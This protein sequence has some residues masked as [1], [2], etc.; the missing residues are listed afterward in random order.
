MLPSH[1][2]LRIT[3]FNSKH[4][5]IRFIPLDTFLKFFIVSL[6]VIFISSP[7]KNRI[8][9]EERK[10]ERKKNLSKK[11]PFSA[12]LLPKTSINNARRVSAFIFY[13]GKMESF[14]RCTHTSRET[15]SE[16][17]CPC[18]KPKHRPGTGLPYI[19]VMRSFPRALVRPYY[20]YLSFS[21][22]PLSWKIHKLFLLLLGSFFFII[23]D[24]CLSFLLPLLSI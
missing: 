1:V 21:L 11:L 6:G 10:K 16:A 18:K 15:A 9:E 5:R 19:K 23:R 24:E 8:I 14:I 7:S 22:S 20:Y 4:C 17:T 13:Q 2:D 3:F 12:G